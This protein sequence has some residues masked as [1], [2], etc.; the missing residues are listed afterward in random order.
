M[1]MCVLCVGVRVG[2]VWMHVCVCVRVYVL[3][4]VHV[5]CLST[6]SCIGAGFD[7]CIRC[8]TSVLHFFCLGR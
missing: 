2:C 3:C 6:Q 4:K 7:V 5:Y 8:V 1:F